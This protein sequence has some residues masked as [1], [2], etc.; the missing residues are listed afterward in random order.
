[1][2]RSPAAV[3]RILDFKERTGLNLTECA[4]RIKM[5]DRTLRRIRKTFEIERTMLGPIADRL[6]I[7]IEE[8]IGE[9]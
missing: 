9:P 4:E 3:R 6:G 8:L 5:S 2:V 1:M 7:S